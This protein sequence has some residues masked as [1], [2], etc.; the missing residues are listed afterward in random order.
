MPFSAIDFITDCHLRSLNNSLSEHCKT[1]EVLSY[2]ER[3]LPE[4]SMTI[5]LLTTM[6]SIKGFV[7]DGIDQYY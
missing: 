6:K 2:D 3:L 5:L 4:H 7:V 1:N